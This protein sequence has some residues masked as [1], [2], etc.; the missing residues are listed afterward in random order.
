MRNAKERRINAYNRYRMRLSILGP[1]RDQFNAARVSPALMVHACG[2]KSYNCG[3]TCIS[4]CDAKAMC[5]I[6]SADGKTPCGLKLCCSH[7]GWC[8]TE[9]VHCIDPEPQF[10][11]TP[12]QA[13]YGGCKVIPSP[14]CGKDSG[15]ARGRRVGY[16]Q[17][18]NTRE[19]MCERVSPRQINTRGLTHLFYSFAFFHPTTYEIMAMNEGDIPLYGEFT[20]L[21]RNG[22]QTLIAIGGSFNDPNT[23][24]LNAFSNMV[25]SS[26]NRAAFINSLIAFMNRYGFQGADI[27][28]EYPADPKRGG[29]KEDTD[30]LVLLMKEMYEAFGGRYGSSL[31]IAPDYWYPGVS[32]ACI[33]PANMQNYVDFMGFMSYDL[34]GPWD[35]DVKTLGSIVR[36]QTDIT[37]IDRNLKPLWF[38]GVDPGKVNFGIAYYGRTYKL[39]DPSCWKMGCHFLG[40]GAAGPCTNFPGVLSNREIRGIIKEENITPTLNVTAMVKYLKYKGDSWVGYDD[41][42]TYA[43]DRCLGG[44]MIWSID[45]DDK[46]GG[47]IGLDDPNGYNSPESATIIPMSHTTVP[48]GQT[49]TVGGGAA[50]DLPRLPNG[51]NQNIPSGPGPEKCGQCSFFR[52]ITSTCCGTGGSVGN[53]ILIPAGVPTPMDIPLPPAFAPNQSFTD[54]NG[55]LIPANQALPRETIIPRNTVF[56]QPFIIGPGTPLR[57]GESDDQ[58][59][60]SSSHIWLSPH[61]WDDPNP[62][63]QCFFPCTFVLPPWPSFTTTVDYPRITV[64][65]SGT[66]QTTLTFPPLTVS[67]WEPSTIVVDGSRTTSSCPEDDQSRT[68][69]VRIKTTSTWPVVKYTSSGTVHTTRPPTRTSDPPSPPGKDEDPDDGPCF[70][71]CPPPPPPG[72]RPPN[73]TI[74]PGPPRPT[75]TPCAFPA[76]VCPPGQRPRPG[77]GGILGPAEEEVEEVDPKEICLLRPSKTKTLTAILTVSTDVT[78]IVAPEPTP[79]EPPV[80]PQPPT[81]TWTQVDHSKDRVRCYNRGQEALRIHMINPVESYCETVLRNGEHISGGWKGAEGRYPFPCCDRSVEVMPIAVYVQMELKDGCEWTFNRNECRAEFRKIIDGC[82]K[83]G[84][85][86]KQGGTIEGN[87]LRWR[88]DPNTVY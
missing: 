38:D 51:G 3:E 19:R 77:L 81:H 12:C 4:N 10:G 63:V 8:G 67:R 47:G 50:T 31:T 25:S 85:N 79:S 75:T 16:Y 33:Y 27:D 7:Y 11:K 86:R 69:R 35:E 14:T 22:L 48:A 1:S 9:D 45:F 15:T 60:N 70:F 54:S 72:I 17:G 20:A 36:P 64:T 61:I 41:A 46:T 83:S 52:R 6:D 13:G 56:T 82:D 29:R 24:T 44:I 55:T 26:G 2:F 87:C 73:L 32:S 57:E 49:F 18:W 80:M 21:K 76:N 84:E 28:W 62:Q 66:I 68:S 37:E 40:E 23:T 5:G 65:R 58:N 78:T 71:N 59:S 88:V 34:H 30:N 42:E 53:P 43:N 39:M 74:R